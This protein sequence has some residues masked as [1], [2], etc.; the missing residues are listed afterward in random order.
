MYGW[1]ARSDY[2]TEFLRALRGLR[3]R[4]GRP[5]CFLVDEIQSFCPIEGSP[6]TE[7]FLDA[8][9]WGGFSVI[10]YRVSQVAPAILAGLDHMLITRL[11]LPEEL[12]TLKPHLRRYKG[13]PEILNDLPTL[14]KGQAYLCMNPDSYWNTLGKDVIKLRVG[15][16]AV[17]HVRHL[18]KY[19]RAPLPEYKRFYFH[20][21]GQ[22]SAGRSAASLWEF[23]EALSDVSLKSLSYHLER[24]DFEQWLQTVLHD[25]ELARRV[26]KIADHR[27]KGEDLRQALLEVVIDRYE[28][29]DLMA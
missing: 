1:E 25:D 17:P 15:R 24:G 6:L 19:L 23:R 5:H 29:L 21:P 2:V 16:R 12:E 4:R 27:L 9:R 22:D 8:M 13:G 7:L 3:G 11:T 28:E 10:S 14:N 18:H 26:H 20:E